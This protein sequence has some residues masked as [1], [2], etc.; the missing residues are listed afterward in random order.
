[1]FKGPAFV[2]VQPRLIWRNEH[3]PLQERLLCSCIWT[4][5]P[6]FHTIS[7]SIDPAQYLGGSTTQA[8][9]LNP[10]PLT[11][12]VWG[13]TARQDAHRLMRVSGCWISSAWCLLCGRG[14][15][16][17]C[18]LAAWYLE[19]WWCCN[20]A[21]QPATWC[22]YTGQAWLRNPCCLVR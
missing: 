20:V 8:D 19:M 7:Y 12:T 17:P 13:T 1:M 22:C 11:C 10:M 4:V 3:I 21:R 14:A 5:H 18:P 6:S 9:T 2:D 15:C 16:W